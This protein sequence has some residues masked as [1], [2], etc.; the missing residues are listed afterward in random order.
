MVVWRRI[1][2][3]RRF[4]VMSLI[5]RD[6][7]SQRAASQYGPHGSIASH[8]LTPEQT[9][10]TVVS[11]PCDELRLV[12]NLPLR[13][14]NLGRTFPS[15]EA[16]SFSARG[17]S[18]VR[19]SAN[20]GIP[21]WSSVRDLGR[22][23]EDPQKSEGMFSNRC[24]A[25]QRRSDGIRWSARKT[26]PFDEP[27]RLLAVKSQRPATSSASKQWTKGNGKQDYWHVEG[28]RSEK[29][30]ARVLSGSEISHDL[31]QVAT[32]VASRSSLRHTLSAS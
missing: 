29:R 27:V 28:K 11:L 22:K 32:S 10:G 1:Q 6:A 24:T 19:P 25:T 16:W 17:C 12:R 3:E 9:I 30:L 13:Q 8:W 14:R 5:R 21:T 26:N 23:P 18:N 7:G 20:P 4:E 31:F 15:K 2:R